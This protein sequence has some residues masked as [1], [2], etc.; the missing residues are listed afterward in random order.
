MTDNARED[1]AYAIGVQAYIWG[2]PVVINERRS[3]IGMASSTE[4]SRTCCAAP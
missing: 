2:Y 3:H 4:S 1:L